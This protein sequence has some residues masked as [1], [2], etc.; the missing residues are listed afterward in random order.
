MG[1]GTKR[2]RWNENSGRFLKFWQNLSRIGL[3]SVSHKSNW[4]G[5]Y[6]GLVGFSWI[7][8]TFWRLYVCGNPNRKLQTRQTRTFSDR[9]GGKSNR[10]LYPKQAAA[11]FVNCYFIPSVEG[12][13]EQHQRMNSLKEAIWWQTQNHTP[14]LTPN[15]HYTDWSQS[16]KSVSVCSFFR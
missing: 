5:K 3:A 12:Q 10:Q 14:T 8:T 11:T 9:R 7:E 2:D 15:I 13:S 6:T 4:Q 1:C 16:T